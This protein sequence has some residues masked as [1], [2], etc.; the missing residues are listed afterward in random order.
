MMSK[1]RRQGQTVLEMAIALPIFMLLVFGVITVGQI[2]QHQHALNLAAREAARLKAVGYSDEHV[3]AEVNR[4]TATMDHDP[5]RFQ[6]VLT[7]AADGVRAQLTYRERVGMPVLRTLFNNKRITAHA[8]HQF[9]SQWL[10]R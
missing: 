10:P 1:R 9:E 4:L 3:T 8:E 2:Y 6:M 5:S 7:V